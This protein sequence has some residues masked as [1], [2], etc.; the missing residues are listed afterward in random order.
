MFLSIY[1][2]VPEGKVEPQHANGLGQPQTITLAAPSKHTGPLPGH[3]IV[4]A[5]SPADL[6]R[7]YREDFPRLVRVATAITRNE[8]AAVEAVQEA[9]LR[10]LRSRTSYRGQGPLLAWVWRTVVNEAKRASERERQRLPV[11]QEPSDNG[12]GT[13]DAATRALIA[14]LPERQRLAV[15]LRYYADLDYRAIGEVLGIETGTVSATLAAAHQTL[16]TAIE[17]VAR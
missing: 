15:F 1:V 11:T 10:L 4:G 2:D 3:V 5:P 16:R 12:S 13:H 14:A 17:G 7:I 6:E 8:A 9:F